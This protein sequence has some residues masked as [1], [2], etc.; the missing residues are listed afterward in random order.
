MSN[1]GPRTEP[2]V[3]AN[4]HL[5]EKGG[6]LLRQGRTPQRSGTDLLLYWLPRVTKGLVATVLVLNIVLMLIFVFKGYRVDFHSDAAT[7]NL[8]AE[9]IIRTGQ[10]FPRDW[11][12]VN[13]DIWIVFNHLLIVPLLAFMKNGY[14]A[15]ALAGCVWS[16][17]ILWGTWLFAGLATS[18][19]WA[20]LASIAVVAGAVSFAGAENV[21]GQVA[22]GNIFLLACL[23]AYTSWRALQATGRACWIFALASA[24]LIVLTFAG[25]PQRAIVTYFIP[26]CAAVSVY[27]AVDLA[28]NGWRLGAP[29]SRAAA[30][31]AII[32]AAAAVGIGCHLWLLAR[33][34]DVSGA[35]N[36]QWL[37]FNAMLGNAGSTLHGLFGILGGIPTPGAGVTSKGGF[38]E[39][40]RLVVAG[41]IL[42]LTPLVLGF[43]LRRRASSLQF[44]G[45]FAAVSLA[46]F[47]FLQ[48]TTTIPQMVDP[49]GSARYLMPPLLM[50]LV[51]SASAVVSPDFGWLKR[52]AGAGMLAVLAIGSLGP[53]NPLSRPLKEPVAEP[54]A[55]VV[56][57][58]ER[59]GLAYGYASYW[60]AG[61]QTVLS[62]G[63][64][65]ARAI[66]IAGALPAPM[67]HLSSKFWYSPQAW[68][69]ET[70]LM[71]EA[72]EVAAIDWALME[73]YAGPASRQFQ[74][75]RFSVFVYPHNLASVLPGWVSTV[76]VIALTEASPRTVGRFEADGNGSRL[77]AEPGESGYL[78]FGPYTAL[79][80]G[81]YRATFELEVESDSSGE[82]VMVDVAS[83]QGQVTHGS[84][85][86]NSIGRHRSE[87]DFDLA[88]DVDDLEVR[89]LSHGNARVTLS[90][91]S[92][93]ERD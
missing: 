18:S 69:G 90:A 75:E 22:Y 23:I 93:E 36:A 65:R 41:V 26:I 70:F 20:K 47:L 14:A 8:L 57:M 78:H 62:N 3:R 82:L 79:A 5:S 2:G 91:I 50:I 67:R 85:R 84:R 46:L 63:D 1:P 7:K 66:L 56:A 59:E 89:V 42:G 33:V 58:L 24:V 12:F 86:L 61:V 30:L 77:V 92:L 53:G 48:V 74:F 87:V 73:Q 32:G 35:G 11:Y 31:L 52:S 44:A 68:S 76:P 29:A 71:L 6:S 16:V 80:S 55:G 34:L 83:D 39:G 13:S 4:G 43:A 19:R 64:V 25:N 28:T 51:L 15:H 40:I 9:E 27:G 10:L 88:A 60:N 81:R 38:Y 54:Y 72:H 45:L 37:P 49:I 21:F 17:L